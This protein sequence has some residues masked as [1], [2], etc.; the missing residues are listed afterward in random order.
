MLAYINEAL[1]ESMWPQTA[2]TPEG[3]KDSCLGLTLPFL[4]LEDGVQERFPL[5][6]QMKR[7]IC[8]S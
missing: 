6:S 2:E 8:S 1:F 4:E 7:Q 3:Q 5:P